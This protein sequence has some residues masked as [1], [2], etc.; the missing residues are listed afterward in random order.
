VVQN[1]EEISKAGTLIS[2]WTTDGIIVS[3]KYLKSV[4]FFNQH[5]RTMPLPWAWLL[6][7][8]NSTVSLSFTAAGLW[9][10]SCSLSPASTAAEE[11]SLWLS[12][13]TCIRNETKKKKKELFINLS[14]TIHKGNKKSGGR[15]IVFCEYYVLWK[16]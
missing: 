1:S 2:T 9:K 7:V 15:K 13:K 14:I 4:Y 3:L 12:H 8:G 11:C 10:I 16:W 6:C 5:G